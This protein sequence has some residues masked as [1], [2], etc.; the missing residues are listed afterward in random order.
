MTIAQC[1]RVRLNKI[2]LACEQQKSLAQG[3]EVPLLVSHH[4]D[5]TRLDRL[6]RSKDSAREG[7]GG[8]R[9]SLSDKR[10]E[11]GILCSTVQC[12]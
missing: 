9:C 11:K 7:G 10:K 2:R 6:A 4:D 12:R 3:T 8:Y 1:R 5:E